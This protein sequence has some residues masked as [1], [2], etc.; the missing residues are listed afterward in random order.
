MGLYVRTVG[1]LVDVFVPQVLSYNAMTLLVYRNC[2]DRAAAT[3]LPR[4]TL[5]YLTVLSV[6]FCSPIESLMQLLNPLI[7]S[8]MSLFN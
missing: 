1:I 7:E 2:R 3:S 4:R 8:L 6:H 5:V